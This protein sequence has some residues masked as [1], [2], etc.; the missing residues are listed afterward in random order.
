LRAS[1]FDAELLRFAIPQSLN[2][3]L[4]K[5]LTRLDVMMLGALG[6]SDFELGLF[7]AAAMITTNIREVKLIFSGAL[8]PVIARHH[9]LGQRAEFEAVLGRVTRWS[10]TIAVPIVLLAAALRTDLM[11]VVSKEYA[12]ADNAFF[13][14]LLVPPLLS[15]AF[16]LAGNCIVYTGHSAYNLLNSVLV[17]IFNTAFS[18]LLIPRFGLLGA[19]WATAAAS[20]AISGLQ[21]IELSALEQVRLRLAAIYKPHIGLA[22][23]SL[24][25]W[26]VWDPA[27]LSGL[28]RGGVAVG[29]V[30]AYLLLMVVLRHE[31][32]VGLLGRWL[33]RGSPAA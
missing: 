9:A 12:R 2:M 26:L 27:E 4:T 11:H 24:L 17:A 21:L 31:E 10:T 29:V 5:Y 8:G 13:L 14:I 33:R 15:C 3:T 32:L 28:A 16:G 23:G 22:M 7:G 18:Y 25:L 6:H 30:S 20:L 19:A 1:R